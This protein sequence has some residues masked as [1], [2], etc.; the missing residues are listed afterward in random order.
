MHHTAHVFMFLDV[1]IDSVFDLTQYVQPE[2]DYGQSN[3]SRK[4]TY[5]LTPQLS[6]QALGSLTAGCF[7]P[8]RRCF[9]SSLFCKW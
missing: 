9:Y 1:Y 6:D 5:T 3:T 4:K 8:P 2:Y 7:L